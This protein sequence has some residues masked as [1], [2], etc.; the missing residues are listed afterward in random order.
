MIYSAVEDSRLW[1]SVLAR[2]ADAVE[3]SGASLLSHD[4]ARA[5][6]V[7]VVSGLN[8]E[9]M[10]LYNERYHQVDLWA[11]SPRFRSLAKAELAIPDEAIL[12]RAS[13]KKTEW[14]A[15]INQYE[16]ARMMHAVLRTEPGGATGMSLHRR[17]RDRPF[18]TAEIRFVT[19]LTPHLQQALRVQSILLEAVRETHAALDGLDALQIGALLVAAD[20]TVI[21]ANSAAN[22]ILGRRDG[23]F[24]ER[25]RLATGIV[26]TTQALHALIADC[27]RTTT[28]NGLAAG[29]P[30]L[31]SRVGGRPLQGLVAPVRRAEA[32]GVRASRVAAIIF[33]SDPDATS[34]PSAGILQA[35][36]GFTPTE[37]K[38]ASLLAA[39]CSPAEIADEYGYTKETVH[40]YS[41]QIVAKV[42]SR[43][44]AA[45][46]RELSVTLASLIV[47]EQR[48]SQ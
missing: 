41:K 39:G 42:G 14:F 37:S 44:R 1:Q 4:L 46:V 24:M 15:F 40:W 23:L 22:G 8:P 29:E 9:T 13:L 43:S 34:V 10:R 7:A 21:Y 2:I 3:A 20:G 48:K 33:V 45:M 27:A 17:E 6:A 26:A 16:I 12:S 25:S 11:L 30:I 31:L 36:Y 5:G 35:F 32:M 19:A 28:G 18:G 38:V 47:R